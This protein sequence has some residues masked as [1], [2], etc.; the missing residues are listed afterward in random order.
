M[1]GSAGTLPGKVVLTVTD[2]YPE[3]ADFTPAATDADGRYGA[4][5]SCRLCSVRR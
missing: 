1:N 2:Q 4:I 5:G 3:E